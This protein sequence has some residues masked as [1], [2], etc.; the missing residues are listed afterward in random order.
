M[1]F[2]RKLSITAGVVASTVAAGVAFAYWTTSGSGDG[3]ATAA[4]SNGVVVLHGSFDAGIYPG[5]EKSV[6]FTADN[7][8][9][10]DLRVGTVHLASVTTDKPGCVVT[11]FSMDDVTSNTTVLAS[12][13]H[14]VISGTG[15]LK[16]ANDSA[17]SQDA[18]KGAL[19]TLHLTS[20]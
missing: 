19:I 3:Q 11:D 17:N 8:N 2:S 4:A 20:N 6:S 10:T 13:D 1:R 14:Q 16:F 12:A 7:S 5:G 15:T 9:A 18:C